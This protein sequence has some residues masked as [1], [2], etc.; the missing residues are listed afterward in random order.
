[1]LTLSSV[2]KQ[3][4]PKR[5][6]PCEWSPGELDAQ[7]RAQTGGKAAML[8][9]IEAVPA[10]PRQAALMAIAPGTALL[11]VQYIR[12]GLTGQALGLEHCYRLGAASGLCVELRKDGF[13]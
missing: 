6:G 7:M 10:T 4:L 9:R 13:R 8:Q 1:M 5:M 12:Y 3:S 2:L 11:H